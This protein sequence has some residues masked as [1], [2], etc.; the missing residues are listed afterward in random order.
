[1]SIGVYIVYIVPRPRK[2]FSV[3]VW[4]LLLASTSVDRLKQFTYFF[5]YLYRQCGSAAP[6]QT[7][8]WGVRGKR[9]DPRTGVL[10]AGTLTTRPPHLLLY[11]IVNSYVLYC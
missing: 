9:C 2:A 11:F 3:R 10:E 7:A 5:H 8:L 4:S 1:M 6:P